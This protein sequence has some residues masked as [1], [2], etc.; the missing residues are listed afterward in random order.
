[1][2]DIT[3]KYDGG[4][5]AASL[6]ITLA[7][8]ASDTNLL[9]GRQ[10]TAISNTTNKYIDALVGGKIMTGTSPTADRNIEVWAWGTYD[11]T[12]YTAGMGASDA[13]KTVTAK[14]KLLLGLVQSIPTSSTS[15]NAYEWGPRSVARALGL[16]QLPRAWGLW[17]V[18][19]TGVNLN[20]TGGN[21]EIKFTGV[22]FESA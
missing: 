20:S 16:G 6:T 14:R 13:N 7:S 22:H 15:D 19:N 8:L 11:G 5:S 21:H 10:S 2:A 12:T 9:A 3:L 18:H 4:G 1:M 17:V